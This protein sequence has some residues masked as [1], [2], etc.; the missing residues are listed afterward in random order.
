M[1]SATRTKP[2]TVPDVANKLTSIGFR[3][4]NLSSQPS[5]VLVTVESSAFTDYVLKALKC[6]SA[7]VTTLA[8][9]VKPIEAQSGSIWSAFMVHPSKQLFVTSQSPLPL[10]KASLV[11]ILDM[12]E[13]LGVSEAFVC[14]PK[15]KPETAKLTSEY[16]SMGFKILTPRQQ[17]MTNFVV[18]RFDF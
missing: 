8:V 1:L 14:I 18:L 15:D 3:R 13:Q 5:E 11:A 10:C 7:D 9:S 12:A 17:P 16:S 2:S 4:S 6:P